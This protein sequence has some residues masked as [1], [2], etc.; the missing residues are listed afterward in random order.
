L[1]KIRGLEARDIERHGKAIIENIQRGK[2][3]PKEDWPVIKRPTP[4]SNQQEAM[5]DALMALLRKCCDEQNITPVAVATRKDIEAL[6]RGEDSPL[7]HGW[8]HEIVGHQLEA[9]LAGEIQL[10]AS[11]TQL[12]IQ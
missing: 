12:E 3:V 1:K 11:A 10:R 5:V 4:L 2:A 9:F 7:A 6:I 8:R